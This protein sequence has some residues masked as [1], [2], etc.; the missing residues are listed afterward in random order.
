MNGVLF[1]LDVNILVLAIG[2]RGS[3][4]LR[5]DGGDIRFKLLLPLPIDRPKM[6][7]TLE[8]AQLTPGTNTITVRAI[9][10]DSGKPI[11]ARVMAGDRVLGDV[12]K[13][14]TLEWKRGEKRPEIWVTSLYDHYND[15]VVLKG[16]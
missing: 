9:D 5:G 2:V 6:T 12:N 4:P 14:L 1:V 8:P 10:A 3:L 11:Y 15:V 16:E 7:A 13:P